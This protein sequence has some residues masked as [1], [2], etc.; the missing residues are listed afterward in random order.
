MNREKT[1]NKQKYQPKTINS[2]NLNLFNVALVKHQKNNN[3]ND[4]DTY[5]LNSNTKNSENIISEKYSDKMMIEKYIDENSVI[6]PATNSLSAS[7]KSKGTLFDST[8][9]AK[10]NI[11]N[12][13]NGNNNTEYDVNESDRT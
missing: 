9:I 13:S 8:N 10:L 12:N 7:A 11:T 3:N 4:N 1:S 5:K 2:S 6:K